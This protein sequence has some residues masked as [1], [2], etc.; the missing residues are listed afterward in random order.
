[1]RALSGLEPADDTQSF[2]IRVR[3]DRARNDPGTA[4]P[5]VRIE[6]VNTRTARQFHDVGEAL[7][8]LRERIEDIVAGPAA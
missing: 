2:V 5:R 1:M 6:H 8:H 4:V 7:S 3:L